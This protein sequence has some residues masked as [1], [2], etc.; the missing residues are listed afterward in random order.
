MGRSDL[1][2]RD[3]ED[4]ARDHGETGDI[5]LGIFNACIRGEAAKSPGRKAAGRNLL[6]RPCEPRAR[7]L[8]ALSH[9][10]RNGLARSFDR[11]SRLETHH[12]LPSLQH[13]ASHDQARAP[14]ASVIVRT[15]AILEKRPTFDRAGGSPTLS[16]VV[17]GRTAMAR[18]ACMNRLA[19]FRRRSS[20]GTTAHLLTVLLTAADTLV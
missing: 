11:R 3:R 16:H 20:F 5:A 19:R 7:R 13:G 6:A 4:S 8:S 2:R 17:R 10:D 1:R 18:L 12:A 9:A 14:A 15:S